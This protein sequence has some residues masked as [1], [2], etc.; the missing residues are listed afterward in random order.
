MDNKKLIELIQQNPDLPVVP[1]VDSEVCDDIYGWYM[2]TITTAKVGE[3]AHYGDR[4][5]DDREDFKE[6]YCDDNDNWLY[7]KF[8]Y[9]PRINKYTVGIWHTKE[10]FIENEKHRTEMDEYLNE[11]A[12]DYFK[13]AILVYIVAPEK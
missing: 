9:N 6:D 1:M 10:Q 3:Y 13:K 7:E 2:G 4:W 5:Y 12:E 8:N 11:V